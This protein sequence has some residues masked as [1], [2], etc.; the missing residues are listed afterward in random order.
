MSA[1]KVNFIVEPQVDSFIV[2]L[3]AQSPVLVSET[4]I[5]EML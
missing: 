4:E 1:D 2:K 3:S 5:V